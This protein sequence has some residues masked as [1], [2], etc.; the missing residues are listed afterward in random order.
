MFFQ[1]QNVKIIKKIKLLKKGK[2]K[3]EYH[4]TSV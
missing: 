1:D 2:V 4:A 3:K